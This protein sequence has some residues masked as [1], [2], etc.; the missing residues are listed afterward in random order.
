MDFSYVV[1]VVLLFRVEG[2][3]YYC[4]DRNILMGMNFINMVKMFKCVGNDDIIIIK[5]DDGSDIVIFMFESFSK[6]FFLSYFF[7][8]G[9]NLYIVV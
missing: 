6:W 9:C 1:F 5:V 8:L 7:R 3:E 2:F 4:C